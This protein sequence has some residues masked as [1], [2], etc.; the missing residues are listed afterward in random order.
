MPTLTDIVCDNI[1]KIRLEHDLSS[2]ELAS[3]ANMPQKT[4]HSV[5]N[6]THVPRLDT[7]E[8]LCKTMFIQPQAIVTPSLPM[9]M[10]MSRRI[11]KLINSYKTLTPEQRDQVEALMETLSAKGEANNIAP[12]SP[13]A[14]VA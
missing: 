4:V 5:C 11:G 1:N 8:A 3:R 6:Q 2:R 13:Y 7:V 12:V 14:L 9:N 10:L